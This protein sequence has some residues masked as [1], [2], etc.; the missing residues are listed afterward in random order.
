MAEEFLNASDVVAGLQYRRGSKCRSECDVAGLA[1][2][3]KY[4]RLLIFKASADSKLR[5][6]SMYVNTTS[7]WRYGN[8]RTFTTLFVI[9]DNEERLVYWRIYQRCWCEGIPVK[10]C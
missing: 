10:A 9:L 6:R 7:A 3:A 2:S 1:M 5:Q 8:P 4:F